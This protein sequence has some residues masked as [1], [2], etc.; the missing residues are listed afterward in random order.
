MNL[1]LLGQFYSDLALGNTSIL[2]IQPP[3]TPKWVNKNLINYFIS[4]LQTTNSFSF[5][6]V[7]GPAIGSLGLQVIEDKLCV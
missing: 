3:P 5:N 1:T 2:P 6:V 7:T 4:Y